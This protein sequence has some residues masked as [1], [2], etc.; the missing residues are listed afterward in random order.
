MMCLCLDTNHTSF[1]TATRTLS[2][3]HLGNIVMTAKAL[4]NLNN[5]TSRDCAQTTVNLHFVR[6][7]V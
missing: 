6:T 1:E 2:R 3:G 4:T 5:L 7:T